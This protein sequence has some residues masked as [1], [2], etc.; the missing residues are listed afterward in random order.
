MTPYDP[1]KQGAQYHG[2]YSHTGRGARL[3]KAGD[4]IT[5]RAV[6]TGYR[7]PFLYNGA[8]S[9]PRRLYSGVVWFNS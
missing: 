7:A 6:P 9:L 5:A 1:I 3:L 4:V 2:A 8:P